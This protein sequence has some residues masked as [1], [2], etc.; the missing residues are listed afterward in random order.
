M[1]YLIGS[2]V[3]LVTVLVVTRSF[4]TKDLSLPKQIN[5]RQSQSHIY[6]LVGMA[7][8]NMYKAPEK[9]PSQSTKH[10]D[11]SHVRIIFADNK[12][13]WI[14][15]STFYQAD[16]LDSGIDQENAKAVDIMGMDKVQLD[17]MMFIVEKLTEGLSND[18]SN[19]G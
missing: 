9:L 8:E 18:S 14:S 13:Y 1:E 11:K 7:M 19:S 6:S 15:N 3:T 17:K 16:M 4:I 10:Y 2:L 5:I 12:A